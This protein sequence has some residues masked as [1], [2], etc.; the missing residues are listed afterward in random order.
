MNVLIVLAS[1]RPSIGC[2]GTYARRLARGLRERGHAVTLLVSDEERPSSAET[3]E[4]VRLVVAPSLVRLGAFSLLPTLGLLAARLIPG[5]DVV[6]LHLPGW[7]AAGSAAWCRGARRPLVLTYH[8][9]LAASEGWFNSPVR[10][11]VGLTGRVAGLLADRIVCHTQDFA[12]DSAYLRTFERKTEVIAPPVELMAV[13]EGA[14]AAFRKMARLD[15]GGPVIGVLAPL[16]PG[17]GVEVLLRALPRVMDEYP[18][19][20][21]L[22]A[23]DFSG[24]TG[25]EAR[26]Q[27]LPSLFHRYEDRWTFLGTLRPV[28]M[29][30][31]YPNL[32]AIVVPAVGSTGSFCLAQAEAMLCGTPS[33]ASDLP[34]VREPVRQTGMGELVPVG[35][36]DALA[37]A[38][39]RVVNDRPQYVR[40]REEIEERWSTERTAAAY[41]A[42]FE[43]LVEART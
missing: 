38:I 25:K 39:I 22:F 32:D 4:G 23:G 16:V 14:V 5:H 6:N 10:L 7:G 37:Q 21:V 9:D 30:A 24:A 3:E 12:R 15:G 33:I 43:R 18:T 2:Q 29:A 35:D 31:F 27:D 42:L 20:R 1:Y 8:R 28:Q 36:S 13:G 19:A 40:P 34:G 41:E 26:G 17:D 11:G